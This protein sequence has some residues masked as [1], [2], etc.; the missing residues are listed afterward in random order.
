MK[1]AKVIVNLSLDRAF[2]YIIP[3]TLED[4]IKTGV[5]VYVPFGRSRRKGYVV[6]TK[7]ASSYPSDRLKEIESVCDTHPKIPDELLR[8]AEWICEYYCC[9]REQAVRA[10]LPSAV[11]SGKIKHRLSKTYYL[12]SVEDAHKYILE[13]PK[14][15]NKRK[16]ILK[17]LIQNPGSYPEIIHEKTGIS[18]AVL[19]QLMKDGQVVEEKN[20][21]YRTPLNENIEILRTIPHELTEE[22]QNALNT[23]ESIMNRTTAGTRTIL[24]Y[25]VTGS[26]KTE[27]YMR[28]IDMAIKNGRD[29]I[30]LVPESSYE[31]FDGLRSKSYFGN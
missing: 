20:K 5:M 8:L 23:V 14:K 3:Y 25:G 10:L 30:V 15:Y 31:T 29:A 16:E 28:A 2:D 22:Q 24:L 9:S 19:K 21:T 1:I 18:Q 26:G 13:A 4:S 7:E 27:V 6:G 12:S 11:R 17:Y